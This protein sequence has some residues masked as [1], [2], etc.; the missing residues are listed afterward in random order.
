MDIKKI[1]SKCDY[2]L[3]DRCATQSDIEA[4][5]CCGA[6]Y[7]VASVCIPPCFVRFSKGMTGLPV[8]T[9]IGFP[10][11]YNSTA[12]K[13]YEAQ[14]ALE[15]G[16]D[17]LDAVINV[18]KLKEKDY[19][20]VKN[21]ILALKKACGDRILKIIIEACLLTDEEKTMMCTLVTEGGADFI[22]TSTGFLSGAT[23]H[24]VELLGRNVGAGVR[25][26]A[27]GGIRTV[28]AAQRYIS[29]GADRIGSSGIIKDA[30]AKGLI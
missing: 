6:K 10:N 4:R 20:Y 28:E 11:G 18:G 30:L 12:A 26:K 13:L 25:V 27:A 15:S 24:D 5:I 3:L 2:T 16:A 17:E 23:E 8:C 7:G 1:L 21:E 9:V 19:S 29:L 22:K 14:E